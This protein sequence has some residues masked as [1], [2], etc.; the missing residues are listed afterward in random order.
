MFSRMWLLSFVFSGLNSLFSFCLQNSSS[1]RHS[2]SSDFLFV[3]FFYSPRV[4]S[5]VVR[6]GLGRVAKV[7][8]LYVVQREKHDKL[9]HYAV[10]KLLEFS[11]VCTSKFNVLVCC[12]LCMPTSEDS[13]APVSLLNLTEIVWNLHQQEECIL[14]SGNCLYIPQNS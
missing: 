11:W 10:W 6:K 9:H 1:W 5:L 14:L 8:W 7:K 4:G 2:S 3:S 13:Y 12:T